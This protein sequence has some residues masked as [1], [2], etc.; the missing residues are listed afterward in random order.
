VLEG[1]EGKGG[2]G[3]QQQMRRTLIDNNKNNYF[4]LDEQPYIDYLVINFCVI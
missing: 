1:L 3:E 2:K 4:K